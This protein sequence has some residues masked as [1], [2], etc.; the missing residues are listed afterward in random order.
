MCLDYFLLFP[1]AKA[2]LVFLDYLH[3]LL[4]P[5]YHLQKGSSLLVFYAVNLQSS[6]ERADKEM[7]FL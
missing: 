7:I 1:I 2:V 4:E 5:R 3:L 6:I